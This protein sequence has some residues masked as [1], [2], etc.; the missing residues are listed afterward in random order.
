MIKTRTW[1]AVIGILS[2]LSCLCLLAVEKSRLS[3]SVADICLDNECIRSIDLSEVEERYI[4][5]ISTEAGSN[6]ICVEPGRICILE[7]D[8]PDG[9]CVDTGW[10]SDSRKPIV[11][12]PHRLV[13][14]L[15]TKGGAAVKPDNNK[16]A[17]VISK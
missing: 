2:L 13:I 8:C 14:R 3:S 17:D 1:I 12:L 15:E 10:L 11:C 9:I 6:T 7:A 4:F 16:Q 5:T